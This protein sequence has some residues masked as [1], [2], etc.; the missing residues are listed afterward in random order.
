MISAQFE[1][2]PPRP[3]RPTME[4][5]EALDESLRETFPASDVPSIPPRKHQPAPT[6]A[7]IDEPV[8]GVG[9]Q[10]TWGWSPTTRHVEARQPLGEAP[11]AALREAAARAAG[12][13]F[14]RQSISQEYDLVDEASVESFPA[15]D[16]PSWTAGRGR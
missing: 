14:V 11:H 5:E 13:A 4:E 2:P 15:S 6:P 10:V 9:E 3:S 16:P 1:V 7:Q 8:S 12:A